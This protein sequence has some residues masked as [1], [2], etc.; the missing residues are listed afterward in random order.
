MVFTEFTATSFS[1]VA[2]PAALTFPGV[3]VKVTDTFKVPSSTVLTSIPETVFDPVVAV[4]V[5]FTEV[6]PLLMV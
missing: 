3:S 6:A 4:I 1:T 5:P 2:V